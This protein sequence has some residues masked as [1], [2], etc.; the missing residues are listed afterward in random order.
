MSLDKKKRET[1]SVKGALP[2]RPWGK[3][4]PEVFKAYVC[5]H[6]EFICKKYDAHFGISTAGVL[7]ALN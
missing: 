1:G 3:L 2:K 5:K 7:K 6:P 4:D